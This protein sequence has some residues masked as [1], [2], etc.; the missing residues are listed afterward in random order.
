MVRC[1]HAPLFLSACVLRASLLG[2]DAAQNYC[3]E[4]ID[5]WLAYRMEQE[6]DQPL[7]KV[8]EA[9]AAQLKRDRSLLDAVAGLTLEKHDLFANGKTRCRPHMHL[10][11]PML[12]AVTVNDQ[13]GWLRWA[14]IDALDVKTMTRPYVTITVKFRPTL[15]NNPA[16]DPGRAVSQLLHI[17][18]SHRGRLS[19]FK[20]TRTARRQPEKHC[21]STT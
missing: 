7:D 19:L 11:V 5:G 12:T 6:R 17:K 9:R 18:R 8:K 10:Q 21:Q 1:A 4:T 2:P 20:K 13:L 14:L 3:T 15:E 16:H